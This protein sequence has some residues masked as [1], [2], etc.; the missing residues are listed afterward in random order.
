[1]WW[2]GLTISS[3]LHLDVLTA[4]TRGAS[5]PRVML[6][7]YGRLREDTG[8]D[9]HVFLTVKAIRELG[10]DV[11]L[12]HREVLQIPPDSAPSELLTGEDLSIAEVPMRVHLAEGAEYFAVIEFL[13]MGVEYFHEVLSLNRM[14]RDLSPRTVIIAVNPDIIHINQ[15]KQRKDVKRPCAIC[16]T[17]FQLEMSVWKSADIVAGV[18]KEFNLAVQKLLPN[19]TLGLAPYAQLPMNASSV[20]WRLRSDVIYFGTA[21]GANYKSLEY[22]VANTVPELRTR[23]GATLHVYGGFKE[24][25]SQAN[26]VMHGIVEADVLHEA[27]RRSRWMVAPVVTNIGVSTKIVMALSLGTPVVTTSFGL[28]GMEDAKGPS[29]FVISSLDNFTNTVLS[30]YDDEELWRRKQAAAASFAESNFGVSNLRVQISN[31]IAKAG[32]V[33][34]QRSNAARS[35]KDKLRVAWEVSG[36]SGSMLST[37]QDAF[38]LMDDVVSIPQTSPCSSDGSSFDIYLRVQE[39]LSTS[40]PICCPSGSCRFILLSNWH[41]IT[42]NNV[43]AG[44]IKREVDA[45]WAPSSSQVSILRDRGFEESFV[46]FVPFGIDC[47]IIRN[48]PRSRDVRAEL[49]LR[50]DTF[51]FGCIVDHFPSEYMDLVLEAFPKTLNFKYVLVFFS[52]SVDVKLKSSEIN[53]KIVY[54]ATISNHEIYRAIDILLLPVG[55]DFNLYHLE[56][57]ILGKPIIAPFGG[58]VHDYVTNFK[59]SALYRLVKGEVETMAVAHR[60]KSLQDANANVEHKCRYSLKWLVA[61]R[62]QLRKEIKAADSYLDFVPGLANTTADYICQQF[63]WKRMARIVAAELFRSLSVEAPWRGVRLL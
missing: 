13:W 54:D 49:N 17:Y 29:P 30:V 14:L 56:T 34:K 3:L 59:W 2:L 52:R 47:S 31:L 53:I 46:R 20:P 21:Y 44:S 25:G 23:L 50:M 48:A 28:G 61:S 60:C 6:V 63:Q 10:Y 24:Y 18:N 32:V 9:L 16:D 22:L 45:L 11:T 7:H 57:L 58:I 19:I 5:A 40:R 27:I 41:A 26:C 15:R 8:G 1:M 36:G 43:T 55:S 12:C 33:H 62:R 42:F 37:V 38:Q 35:R 4:G 39:Q 51:V